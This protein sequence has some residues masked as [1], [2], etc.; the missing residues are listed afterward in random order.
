MLCVATV[1][2][3]ILSKDDLGGSSCIFAKSFLITKKMAGDRAT[4]I[5]LM[6]DAQKNRSH[7]MC[8]KELRKFRKLPH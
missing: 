8:D 3:F 6:S 4:C 1:F 5:V 7:P 2:A